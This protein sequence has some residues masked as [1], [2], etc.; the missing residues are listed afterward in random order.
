MGILNV[1]DEVQIIDVTEKWDK[2][3][4]KKERVMSIIHF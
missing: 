3:K 2:V 1:G 4:Y